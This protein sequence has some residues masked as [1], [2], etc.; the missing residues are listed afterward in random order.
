MALKHD[1]A[2]QIQVLENLR[3]N[4]SPSL[5]IFLKTAALFPPLPWHYNCKAYRSPCT[6]SLNF[7][8][9]SLTQQMLLIHSLNTC[10][11]LSFGQELYETLVMWKFKN[12]QANKSHS[13]LPQ[14]NRE[15]SHSSVICILSKG[16]NDKEHPSPTAPQVMET[17]GGSERSR[18]R[19][20]DKEL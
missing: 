15:W 6:K 19:C 8:T 20:K 4:E 13:F 12:K 7:Q 17:K 14:T 3:L 11:R 9:H 5:P 10:Y 2:D 16:S 18:T 1:V